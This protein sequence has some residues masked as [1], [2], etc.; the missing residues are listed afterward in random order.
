MG[1]ID[2]ERFLAA[3]DRVIGQSRSSMGI[4]TLSEKTVHSV[5]KYYFEPDDDNHEVALDGYFADIY[6][7]KGVTEIQ[8][9]SFNRLRE[10]LAVFLNQYPVTV[11][12]PLAANTWVSRFDEKSGEIITRRKSP[13]HYNV[14]DAFIELYKIKQ[15]LNYEDLKIIL[16]FMDVEEYKLASRSRKVGRKTSD[17]L[18][19]I[20]IGIT[21]VVSIER[22]EDY[23]QFVPY[24]LENEFT[25]SQ[26]AKACGIAREHAQMVLNILNYVGAVERVGKKERSYLY[27]AKM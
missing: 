11:V 26:F 5:L 2:N 8:T 22:P 10:K 23:M 24:E 12:Y 27:R 13:R 14:Y 6:N 25:S 4:G 20:P 17:K 15:Y 9:R 18:D 21:E 7:D 3:K 16:V 19:K 1:Y